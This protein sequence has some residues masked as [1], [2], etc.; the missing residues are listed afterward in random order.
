MEAWSLKILEKSG[1]NFL[2]TTMIFIN[3]YYDLIFIFG[4]NLLHY[5]MGSQLPQ[6]PP[7]PLQVRPRKKI[8]WIWSQRARHLAPAQ[9]F[10]YF[11][12]CNL[13]MVFYI[14]NNKNCGSRLLV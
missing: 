5:L 7:P 4:S 9:H 12:K 2:K 11:H 13:P 6:K 14:G 3:I 1:I 8:R 10:F